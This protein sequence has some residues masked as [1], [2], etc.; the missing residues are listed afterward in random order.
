VGLS[1]LLAVV[2]Y[3]P[4]LGNGHAF[5]DLGDIVE[6]TAVHGIGNAAEILTTPYRARV[7]PV[8][9]PYRPITSLS[10]AVSW[11]MGDGAPFPFH[12]FNVALH[13]GNTAAVTGLLGVL[14]ANPLL[15]L[16]GGAI[17]AVHPVHSEAVAN[18]VGRGDALM[19]LFV[20]LGVLAYLR[21]WRREWLGVVAVAASYALALG[22]KENGVVLPALLV[23]VTLVHPRAGRSAAAGSAPI[24][25]RSLLSRWPLFGVLAA[26]LAAFLAARYQVLGTLFHRDAAPYIVILPAATRVATAIANFGELVRLL[27]VPA[28]LAADY[29]PNVIV[30]AAVSSVRFWIGLCLAVGALALGTLNLRRGGWITLG[31]AWAVL[32]IAVVGNLFFPVGVWVAERT[33]YLPSV[34]VSFLAVGAW[35]RLGE[36]APRRAQSLLGGAAVVLILL[37]GARTWTRNAA[38]ADTEAVFATLAEEHPESFRAQWWMGQALLGMGEIDRGIEW[39]RLAGET[40]PNELRIQLDYVRGLLL[41]RRSEEA[42]A[43]VSKL[44]LLDPARAVYLT[45]SL[46]QLNRPDEARAAVLDGLARFP[47][48]ARLQGQAVEL[49][50]APESGGEPPV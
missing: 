29:G 7:P 17:F 9:S 46:I 45:Q 19:T 47:G 25:W 27:L 8:R 1:V 48:D 22:A 50:V 15:A 40:N 18:G 21:P 30:P 14:G 5:D 49:G 35:H 44:P 13:A 33:L 37:G 2:V 20:L 31:I 24:A 4:S 3:L 6:N 42:Y 26:V 38:W 16:V 32:A 23:L 28:D 39:L 41:A 10:Y 34:G 12:A 43:I 11:S 36:G